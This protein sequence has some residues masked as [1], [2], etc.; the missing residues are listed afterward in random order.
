MAVLQVGK[1]YVDRSS[2]LTS[3]SMFIWKS[4]VF[5]FINKCY[6]N[7]KLDL[8]YTKVSY[9]ETTWSRFIFWYLPLCPGFF[10][11]GTNATWNKSKQ[12]KNIQFLCSYFLSI[13]FDVKSQHK[14]LF[15]FVVVKILPILRQCIMSRLKCVSGTGNTKNQH[16]VEVSEHVRVNKNW[17]NNNNKKIFWFE[18]CRVKKWETKAYFVVSNCGCLYSLLIYKF[19]S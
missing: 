1:I 4:T 17:K 11:S 18:S 10:E 13:M 12:T 19:V 8:L 9:Q 14:C 6:D 5:V 15:F 3:Q 2:P 16:A 7:A